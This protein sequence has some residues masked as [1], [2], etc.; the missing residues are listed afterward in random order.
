M[1][2]NYADK[3]PLI[4]GKWALLTKTMHY[5]YRW[6]LP[7]LY[8][9]TVDEFTRAVRLGSVSVTLG[10]VKEYQETMGEIAFHTTAR[11]FE[12]YRGLSVVLDHGDKKNDSDIPPNRGDGQQREQ[13]S[14]FPGTK[15]E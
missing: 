1:S 9:N 4:F 12:L 7:V 11:L 13:T 14:L 8:Q 6:F 5:A 3:L 2:R 15:T 10:G